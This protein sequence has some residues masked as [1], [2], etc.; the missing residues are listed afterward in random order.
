MGV[1]VPR[2]APFHITVEAFV[3]L[4]KFVPV[5]VS[6][7]G[8]VSPISAEV[9][10]S[11]PTVG[12]PTVNV[13]VWV[14]TT[15]PFETVTFVVPTDE[16][17]EARTVAVIWVPAVLTSTVVSGAAP[18]ITV[19]APVPVPPTKLV[20]VTVSVMLALPT[21]IEDGLIALI[22][23]A[24]TVNVMP[25]EGA[26]LPFLTVML[27]VETDESWAVVK[28]AVSCVALTQVVVPSATPFHII[29][30]ALAPLWTKPV[31]LTVSVRPELPTG[32]E[33]GLSDSTVR[34][35]PNCKA[36]VETA[37]AFWTVTVCTPVVNRVVA[38]VAVI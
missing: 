36:G 21:P 14:E 16:S 12:A 10:L 30:E 3:P 2:A 23:G 6:V 33:A 13:G 18:N 35:T 26:P 4:T 38:M 17:W 19:E 27:C 22:V 34:P 32:T 29:L 5:T 15:P 7:K 24:P 11:D 8:V 28:G 37:L 31:P 20:P 25:L 1:V 9:W